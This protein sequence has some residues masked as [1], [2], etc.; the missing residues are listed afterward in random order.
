MKKLL[1]LCFVCLFAIMIFVG[2][3]DGECFK[4]KDS[5][6]TLTNIHW[7]IIWKIV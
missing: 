1:S 7:K 5:F 3:G 4:D 2:C 6:I